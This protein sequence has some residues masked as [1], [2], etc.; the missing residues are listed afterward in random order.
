MDKKFLLGL[1]FQDFWNLREIRASHDYEDTLEEFS[2]MV[3][4]VLFFLGSTNGGV[5][6]TKNER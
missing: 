3:E 1:L 2:S 6:S 5:G 4:S